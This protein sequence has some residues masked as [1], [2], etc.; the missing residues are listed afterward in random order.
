MST[1]QEATLKDFDLWRQA[2]AKARED[3]RN[4]AWRRKAFNEPGVSW[5]DLKD[6]ENAAQD[7]LWELERACQSGENYLVWKLTRDK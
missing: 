2:V 5:Q 7:Y 1:D 4:A 3:L 6:A